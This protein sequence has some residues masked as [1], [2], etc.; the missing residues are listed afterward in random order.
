MSATLLPLTALLALIPA[1]IVP[2]RRTPARDTV[3]WS[4][5]AVAILGTL[6]WI[7]ARQ[8]TGWHTGIST[9]L[10]LTILSCLLLFGALAG[11]SVNGW[12]LMPLLFPYLMVLGVLATLWGQS[13]ERPLPTG[14]P[15]AWIGS[16]I[17]VSVAT[18]GLITL[19]AVAALAAAIQDK[20]LKTKQRTRLSQIL[21]SVTGSE[22]LLVRLLVTSAVILALGF[23]TGIATQFFTT[24]EMIVFDHK[25]L[26]TIAVFVVVVVLLMLHYRSGIRGKSATRLVLLAYL[27]LTLGYP[28]VKFV[29]DII[30][31]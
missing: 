22:R 30:L 10:W 31:G 14:A 20:A 24:G 15:L 25:T 12:R 3:F 18:Y 2:F 17:A 21:P 23:I 29:T 5:L 28:G 7:V 13:P 19:A 8:S 4:T 9:A 1:T 16:H 26:F 27:L 11:L 6:V